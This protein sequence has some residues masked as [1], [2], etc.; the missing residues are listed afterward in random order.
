MAGNYDANLDYSKELQR[1]DLSAEDRTRLESERQNKINDMYGGAEPT[2]AGSSQTFSQ[3]YKGTGG[4]VTGAP[5][6]PTNPATPTQQVQGVTS[7][8]DQ[9]YMTKAELARV[10][11]LSREYKEA[12]ARG[13]TEAMKRAHA[14]AE[15]I[16]AQYKY[17]GGQFGNEYNPFEEPL[18]DPYKQQQIP[19]ANGA[20]LRDYLDRWYAA[21]K[22]QQQ[23]SIDYGTNKGVLE[24]QRAQQDADGMFQNQRDQVALDEAKALDNQALYAEARGDKGGIGKSQ[25]D[26][27]MNTA[28][29]NRLSVNSAQTKLA[30]DTSRQIADL[31]AQGEFEKADALL[32]L[33]QS[34]L[35]QL[36]SLEQWAAEYNLSV[37]QFNASLQQ[38]ESE[39]EVK[40][41]DLMGTYKGQT[42]LGGQQLQFNQQQRQEDKLA[43]AGNIL[44]GALVMPSESQL[45][46]MGMTREDAQN[47]ISAQKLAQAAAAK[48]GS[49]SSRKIGAG[50]GDDTEIKSKLTF[51]QAKS[52]LEDGNY[53]TNAIAVYERDLGTGSFLSFIRDISPSVSTAIDTY[54]SFKKDGRTDLIARSLANCYK[55]GKF[56]SGEAADVVY[57][58]LLDYFDAA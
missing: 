13:D 40:V 6:N 11:Q 1:T 22:Q 19:S 34:Y 27:V 4:T 12:E 10:E 29:Q 41:A 14:E 31:R 24:L 37:A 35:S 33:S 3:V 47:Y 38:W 53:T 8:W 21:A 58:Y 17:S 42:T 44:L 15:K 39:F 32:T 25:Y 46:A 9:Q 18:M 26:T 30:T 16:R 54:K 49:S 28:A 48:T 50:G 55:Y 5:K 20:N 36:M 51:E 45:A 43:N 23:M 52:E 2:M 7:S 57:A 56:G